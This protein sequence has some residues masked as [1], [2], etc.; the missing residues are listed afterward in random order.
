MELFAIYVWVGICN[1]FFWAT[2]QYRCPQAEG[3]P[4]FEFG[5]G[6][7]GLDSAKDRHAA[8]DSSGKD[9]GPNVESKYTQAWLLIV[10]IP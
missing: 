5:D 10:Y 1:C 3:K 4:Q 2:I 9:M 8:E 6:F 7:K